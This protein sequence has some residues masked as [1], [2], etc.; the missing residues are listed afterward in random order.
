[1]KKAKIIATIGPA[2]EN[3]SMIRKIAEAGVDVCRL[4]FSYGTHD[5]HMKRIEMIRKISA[6]T[7]KSIA[8]MQDLQGP[9]IR[10]GKLKNPVTVRRGDILTLTGKSEHK[11]EFCLPTTYKG[12]AND[13]EKGKTI[14][15]AD[16]KI[17]LQVIDV[18]KAAKQIKCKVL[19]GGTILTGKGINLPYTKI[20]LPALTPKDESDAVFG[21]RAGVDYMAISFVRKAD[22]VLKLRRL[23]KRENANI[24]IIAKIE[25]PEAL[26]NIDEIL[27][28]VDGIMVARGDLAVEISFAKVPVAQKAI[29]HAANKKGKIT[30]VATEMLGSMVDNP[31]P[32]RAEVSDVANSILDGTDAVMLSNETATGKDPVN[33][34]KAMAEIVIETEKLFG[35]EAFHRELNL[36]ETHKLGEAMCSAAAFLSYSLSE[37]ALAVLTSTGETARIL[38]KYRPESVIYAATC[39]DV[40]FHKMALFHNVLPIKLNKKTSKKDEDVHL[41]FSLLEKEILKRKLAKPGER[42]LVLAG[43]SHPESKTWSVN[44]INVR[45]LPGK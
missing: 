15:L 36:P 28:V 41:S 9:K 42:L 10:V 5:E 21:A 4:N 16:G 7:G 39:C 33:A 11:S 38:S 45:M 32:S 17:I 25:K 3:P 34:V 8:I 2:C 40:V 19:S 35:K 6:D 43:I 22:D 23:L 12:I 26:D 44:S 27:D 31:L 18:D 24:P 29:I 20:S 30:I 14:L 13:A 1:M 37:K